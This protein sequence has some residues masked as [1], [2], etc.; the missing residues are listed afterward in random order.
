MHIL[1]LVV[2]AILTKTAVGLAVSLAGK[3]ALLK[4]RKKYMAFITLH[5]I[6]RL[7]VLVIT[8]MDGLIRGFA[9]RVHAT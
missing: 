7:G 4:N 3:L 9:M 2:L 8:Q 6:V 1:L 5:N